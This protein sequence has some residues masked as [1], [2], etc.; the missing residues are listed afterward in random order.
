MSILGCGYTHSTSNSYITSTRDVSGLN[1]APRGRSDKPD[2]SRVGVVC[3][4]C[5]RLLSK[6]R[7]TQLLPCTT[8]CKCVLLASQRIEQAAVAESVVLFTHCQAIQHSEHCQPSRRSHAR[9]KNC[10]C[11]KQ[12]KMTSLVSSQEEVLDIQSE[13]I[14]VIGI[15]HLAQE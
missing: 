2:T 8:S 4:L 5:D 1:C 15:G 11:P 9:I 7:Q 6:W 10:F 13:L 14:F 12:I 3:V